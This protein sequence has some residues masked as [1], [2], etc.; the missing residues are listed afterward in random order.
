MKKLEQCAASQE[1]LASFRIRLETETWDFLQKT[2]PSLDIAFELF[3]DLEAVE[4]EFLKPSPDS[5]TAYLSRVPRAWVRTNG[6]LS[7]YLPDDDAYG[8]SGYLLE[9]G[10]QLSPLPLS[11]L[12]QTAQLDPESQRFGLTFTPI[13]CIQRDPELLEKAQTA[14]DPS[15]LSKLLQVEG[16]TSSLNPGGSKPLRLNAQMTTICELLNH[17]LGVKVDLGKIHGSHSGN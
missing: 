2:A 7:P 15:I 16:F 1:N 8:I 14:M 11:L 6:Q 17:E 12:S 5:S 13:A 3:P 10:E 9:I 4:L